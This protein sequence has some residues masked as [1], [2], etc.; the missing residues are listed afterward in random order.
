MQ[1]GLALIRDLDMYGK[2]IVLTYEGDDKY[3]THVGGL[4][5]IFVKGILVIYVTYLF[6]VMFTKGDSSVSVSTLINDV[7]KDVEIL[8]PAKDG[9]DFAF[10]YTG[11]GVDYLIDPTYFK[12]TIQQVEQIWNNGTGTSSTSR[13]KTDIPYAKCGNNFAHEDQDEVRS[14]GIDDYYW[15]TTDEYSVAG[16]YYAQNFNYIEIKISKCTSGA[17]KTNTEIEEAMK[18][19]R[20]TMAIENSVVDMQDYTQP[21]KGVINDANFWELVPGLRK[22]TDIYIRKSQA[23]IQDDYIQL[24]FPEDEEFYQVVQKVDSFESETPEAEILTL[25]FRYDKTSEIY[26]RQIFSLAELLGQ[27]GGFF[28]ALLAIG[29][30]MIFIFSERLFVASI[31]R[32]IYQIDTWQETERCKDKNSTSIHPHK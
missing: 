8:K 28:G 30:V 27:A 7:T 17:W 12:F 13:N 3:R 21:I 31:L 26:A 23:E 20:F 6:Y 22:K 16:T 2:D 19:A 29:S 25:Y 5:S 9:F 4:A 24:G 15:P 14:L 10:S 32:K 18:D 11:S 1:R